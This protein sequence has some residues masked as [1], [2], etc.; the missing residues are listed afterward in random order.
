MK[1]HLKFI[2]ATIG[3]TS[4]FLLATFFTANGFDLSQ[5]SIGVRG[6][7]GYLWV[8]VILATGF[9]IYQSND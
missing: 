2:G 5:I 3:V 1:K 8:M 6:L 7:I 9:S 4:V